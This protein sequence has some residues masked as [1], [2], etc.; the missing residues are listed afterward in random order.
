M[1]RVILFFKSMF[2]TDTKRM[3]NISSPLRSRADIEDNLK[4]IL[5]E[6]ALNMYFSFYN[7]EYKKYDVIKDLKKTIRLMGRNEYARRRALTL[8][9]KRLS[10][11]YN[12]IDNRSILDLLHEKN[13]EAIEDEL[14]RVKEGMLEQKE[15]TQERALQNERDQ[16]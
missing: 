14:R 12:F 9:L 4:N 15:K 8:T 2:S 7:R 3:K 13:I 11:E 6:Q 5:P 1:Q 10:D 16:L